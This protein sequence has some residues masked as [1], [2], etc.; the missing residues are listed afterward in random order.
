L[1][2]VN[3]EDLLGAFTADLRRA[4]TT[5]SL[6]RLRAQYLGKKSAL[7][8]ALS[9]L[10]RLPA[11][12]R[13]AVARRLQEAKATIEQRL[14]D[15]MEAR[16]QEAVAERLAGEWLDLTLPGIAHDTGAIHPLTD[17][18]GKCSAVMRQLGFTRVEGPEVE[19][20]FY[21]FDALN[22]GPHHPARDMQDTFW[23]TGGLLLR[24]HTTTVQ[25]R[26][27]EQKP[28]LPVKVITAG[29]TYRN[30]AVD[31]THLAMFHQF[32]GIW[33]DLGLTFAHL[34]GVL[35][36]IARAVYGDEQEFRFKPKYYPY[37]EP[38]LGMD[39]RCLG[40]DGAG[41]EACHDAGWITI[42]G[43]G[44]I[45]P[46][47]LQ[48]FGYDPDSVGGIAF[49]LGISRIAAQAYGL[50]AMKPLYEQD[51]RVHAAL[52]RGGM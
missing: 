47:V 10:G 19:E 45:H 1:E 22:I 27:L 34:K 7:A 8:A 12:R 51:L 41:C 30:E 38:S 14:A 49:G 17:V 31:P 39:I 46:K 26:V 48:G 9:G 50:P 5:E 16:E 28:E 13:P 2:P 4:S 40:C 3:T 6:H 52:K 15:A 29:R 35:L 24:A 25:V 23:L 36:V 11:D 43:A 20:E 44:M 21:N 18:I 37:T 42:L 32:E 33:V